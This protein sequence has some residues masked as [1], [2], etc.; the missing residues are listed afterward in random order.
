[1]RGF[2]LLCKG[3][4]NTVAEKKK[5]K[6]SKNSSRG[7]KKSK[8]SSREKRNTL[9]AVL[10]VDFSLRWLLRLC[11]LSFI[12]GSFL[13]TSLL[14]I[15]FSPRLRYSSWWSGQQQQ[16]IHSWALCNT[17]GRGC[18]EGRRDRNP[19]STGSPG[20]LQTFIRELSKIKPSVARQIFQ[21]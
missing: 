15:F 7:K 4:S 16:Q 18:L 6:K 1:M 21:L 3:L 2:F 13:L 9:K 17:K 10:P 8:N 5:K 12:F 19:H 20:G 11:K 14:I